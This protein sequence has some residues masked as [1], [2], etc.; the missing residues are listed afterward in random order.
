[1]FAELSTGPNPS[2]LKEELFDLLETRR[3]DRKYRN[4]EE[5]EEET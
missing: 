1:L 5:K 4:N 2:R 3:S